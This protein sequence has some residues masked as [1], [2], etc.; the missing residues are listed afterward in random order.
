M[1]LMIIQVLQIEKILAINQLMNIAKYYN[2]D[3]E[4]DW[5]RISFVLNL[6][7]S[8]WTIIIL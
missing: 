8:M 3:W 1:L 2:G 4:P 7:T 6:I 5:R